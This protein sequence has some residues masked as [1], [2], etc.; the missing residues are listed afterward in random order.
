[1]DARSLVAGLT[2]Y[3]GTPWTAQEIYL[4]RSHLPG[5]RRPGRLA[6]GQRGG[7]HERPRYETLGSWPLR[8]PAASG[9]DPAVLSADS[10]V[11]GTDP[12]V[13][14]PDPAV[15]GADSALPATDQ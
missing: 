15:P 3:A 2:G 13:P 5:G 14:A 12:G 8:V 11:L 9:A 7:E 6:D 1:V 4:I 10:A